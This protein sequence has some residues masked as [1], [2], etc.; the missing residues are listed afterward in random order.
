MKILGINFGHDASLSLIVNNQLVGFIELERVSR[1]KHHVGIL[2]TDIISFLLEHQTDL[3]QVDAVALVGTQ[4]YKAKY[5]GDIQIHE[6]DH[7]QANKLHPNLEVITTL[8]SAGTDKWYDYESHKNRL[9]SVEQK[10]FPVDA[11]PNGLNGISSANLELL[12]SNLK[13]LDLGTTFKPYSRVIPYEITINNIS[14]PAYFVPHHIAHAA[15]GAFYRNSDESTLVISHDGGWPHIKYN[16]GGVFLYHN[17]AIYPLIDPNLFVGQLYQIMGE[18]AGFK[19]AE[20]PGK[21][22]GLA[23]YGIPKYADLICLEKTILEM[24]EKSRKESAS[25][26]HQVL[27]QICNQIKDLSTNPILRPDH[28]KYEFNF[29]NKNL[30]IGIAAN[31]QALVENIWVS[32][33]APIVEIISNS[34]T[35]N[36]V[37]PVV[38]GFSLNCPANS[39][40]QAT[41]HS[42]S[43]NPLPGGSDMG[44]SIGAAAYVTSLHTKKFPINKDPNYRSPAFPPRSTNHK[45]QDISIHQ[46]LEEIICTPQFYARELISGK[47]FCHTDGYSEV[48][49]RAL[50]NRSIIAHAK[51]ES[52]RDKINAHKNRENWRPLAPLVRDCDF[53]KYF[54]GPNNGDNSIYMLYTYRVTDPSLKGVTHSDCTARAQLINNESYLYNVLG[55]IEKLGEPTVLVNT[56]FNVAGEPL[57]ENIDHA[58]K[59]FKALKF[60]YLF[61]NG[62]L[63][64]QKLPTTS[65]QSND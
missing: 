51:L 33:L 53:T 38:G 22:M 18:M 59:S 39:K 52:T 25:D 40:L 10:A 60:D 49:P 17:N 13:D 2:S 14:K 29:P 56:S 57:V 1:L 55:E 61:V 32:V 26:F 43:L 5:S 21:L 12:S 23:A 30:S 58:V 34:I 19:A 44:T 4:W 65:A 42:H 35:I 8:E 63:Y 50:G 54:S 47:I 28:K 9:P 11:V 37:I 20:A 6:M 62:K 31:T 7:N 64:R 16:S 3:N 15:Y 27:N 36:Y 45:I 41:I 46:D 24:A 48:G